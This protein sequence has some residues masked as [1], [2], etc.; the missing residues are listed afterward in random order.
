MQYCE[1][2]SWKP[3]KLKGIML[4]SETVQSSDWNDFESF[5]NC[6]IISWYGQTEKVILAFS[7]K[8]PPE[9]TVFTSY[10]Y[11]YI[12]DPDNKGFGEIIGTTFVNKA[13]PLINYRTGDFAVIE[14][15]NNSLI[16][17]NLEGRWGKDFVFLSEKKRI[18]TSSIN[19][20]S[21]VQS[22]ILFYQ[23]HQKE[24]GKI[25]ITILPKASAKLSSNEILEE[26]KKNMEMNLHEFQIDYKI[27]E[28]HQ[29]VKSARGKRIML[30]Q[31]LP[32]Q[33][34]KT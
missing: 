22:E 3:E 18:P 15:K 20:H 32:N 6:R 19:L 10:G 8:S 29:I 11:P 34:N 28:D 16:L 2:Y 9:Y 7:E 12:C 33:F 27:V 4:G 5:F 17:K 31:D 23:I 24:Y 26:F 21:S 25:E 30:V 13:L 1:L 14:E